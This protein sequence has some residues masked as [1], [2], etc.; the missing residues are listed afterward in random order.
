MRT[1]SVCSKPLLSIVTCLRLF[2]SRS[3]YLKDVVGIQPS[4]IVMCL[5]SEK[6]KERRFFMTDISTNGE[7]LRAL[8]RERYT[9]SIK[10][11]TT[12]QSST[13]QNGCCGENCCTSTTGDPITGNLYSRTDLEEL[14]IIENVKFLKG[15]IET[16]RPFCQIRQVH[17]LVHTQYL[18]GRDND[19][20]AC[21]CCDVCDPL[22]CPFGCPFC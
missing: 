21:T 10:Q 20:W 1:R 11:L 5:F 15:A 2:L 18:Q 4:S 14:P 12:T 9:Q 8:V 13:V 16:I 17:A 3:V 19:Y 22:C 6:Y 7:Q